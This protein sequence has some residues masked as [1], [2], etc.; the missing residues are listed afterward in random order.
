MIRAN[1]VRGGL[2][3][4][5]AAAG[6]LGGGCKL[7]R[8]DKTTVHSPD[9]RLEVAFSLAEGVPHYEVVYGGAVLIRPS[10][11][12]F[13]FRRAHPMQRGFALEGTSRREFKETWKPVWGQRSEILN[14][15]NELTVKLKEKQAPHR[16]MNVIFRVFNDGIGFRYELPEQD[17]L[18]D[19]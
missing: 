6:G 4:A 13:T 12:G 19:F 5:L 3:M 1:L 15:F 7:S 2:I 8:M 17:G 16:R 11:L 18:K 14:H 10:T 9:E